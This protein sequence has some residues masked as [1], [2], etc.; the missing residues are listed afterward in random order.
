MDSDVSE[1]E[2][3]WQA[4]TELPQPT[5][6]M[7]QKQWLVEDHTTGDEVRQACL[8][9]IWTP[10]GRSRIASGMLTKS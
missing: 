7:I 5:G 3:D 9:Y 4:R 6:I 10:V 1:S 2:E 8:H